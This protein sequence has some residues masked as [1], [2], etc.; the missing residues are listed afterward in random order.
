[1]KNKTLNTQY[2]L[3]PK[4][5]VS[6]SRHRIEL[7]LLLLASLLLIGCHPFKRFNRSLKSGFA[8]LCSPSMLKILK[9]M[10]RA[11]KSKEQLHWGKVEFIHDK[12]K[13]YVFHEPDIRQMKAD[14]EL[15]EE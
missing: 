12:A 8:T 9:R 14:S 4:N 2:S 13:G 3:I 10:A 11:G 1:M 7:L 6:S 15:P 5:N